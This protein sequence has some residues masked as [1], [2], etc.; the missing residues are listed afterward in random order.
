M[1]TT[2]DTFVKKYGAPSSYAAIEGDGTGASYEGTWD[3]GVARFV[4]KT[5]GKNPVLYYLDTTSSSMTGPRST[6]VGMSG[7]DVCG[8]F[9]DLGSYPNENGERTLYNYSDSD[10][11]VNT[12]FGTY[13]READGNYALHYYYPTKDKA[14]VELS[15]YLDADGAV[16]R[17]VWTRYRSQV[18]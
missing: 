18:E 17:I 6:K 9:R 2:Y 14:F 12:Q 15:Y 11:K 8:K 7:E 1:K 5:E 10:V 16:T 4:E 3:W 13:R